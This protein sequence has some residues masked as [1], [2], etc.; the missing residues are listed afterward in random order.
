MSTLRT[1][2]WIS[3]SFKTR[4]YRD[5]NRYNP[6]TLEQSRSP[7]CPKPTTDIQNPEHQCADLLPECYVGRGRCMKSQ[8]R[9]RCKAFHDSLG[10]GMEL[11]NYSIVPYRSLLVTLI[12]PLKGTLFK[13]LRHDGSLSQSLKVPCC[14]HCSPC[15]PI[16]PSRPRTREK[17]F[18]YG[19]SFRRDAQDFKACRTL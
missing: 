18:S 6:T 10:L 8:Q 4:T 17:I 16:P 5:Q 12:D 1:Q 11:G 13:L 3:H 14:S 7:Q 9:P 2:T 19:F 15:D